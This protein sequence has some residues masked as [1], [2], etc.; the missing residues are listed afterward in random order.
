[1]QAQFL[2]SEERLADLIRTNREL[3]EVRQKQASKIVELREVVEK[4]AAELT[5]HQRRSADSVQRLTED[6]QSTRRTIEQLRR[7]EKDLFEF[8]SLI[9]RLL[10][11]DVDALTVPN[12]EI[13]QKLETFITKL[14]HSHQHHHL[15]PTDPEFGVLNR[16]P[17]KN[18]TNGLESRDRG[19]YLAGPG[20]AK[21]RSKEGTCMYILF[22]FQLK[23]N[24]V[25]T[26]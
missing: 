16:S 13:V 8:R 5:D 4:Q 10:G 3:E 25:P 14:Q 24:S 2:Q 1:M 15:M 12:Y 9:G 11:L 17:S 26:A 18:L 21:A 7:S 20:V 23:S 19:T 22:R 6:V